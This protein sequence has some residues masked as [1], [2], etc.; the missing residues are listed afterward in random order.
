MQAKASIIEDVS[1]ILYITQITKLT[2][3]NLG[4]KF[5]LLHDASIAKSWE[6]FEK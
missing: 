2:K 5:Y 4:S 3:T 6:V 1:F